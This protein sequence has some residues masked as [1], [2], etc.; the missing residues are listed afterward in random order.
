MVEVGQIRIMRDGSA[1][2]VVERYERYAGYQKH[3]MPYC[4]LEFINDWE[5]PIGHPFERALA[6]VESYPLH[7]NY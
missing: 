5:G 4:K 1:V 6:T 3:N 2:K 7:P